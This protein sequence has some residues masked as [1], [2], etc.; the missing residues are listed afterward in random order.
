MGEMDPDLK[1]PLEREN[2][3]WAPFTPENEKVINFRN[4]VE[5]EQCPKTLLKHFERY[6]SN[7]WTMTWYCSVISGSS[8][9]VVA[10]IFW[11]YAEF[12]AWYS[13]HE[14]FIFRQVSLAFHFITWEAVNLNSELCKPSSGRLLAG[15]RTTPSASWMQTAVITFQANV[16]G[17]TGC[18][19]Q[20]K[21]KHGANCGGANKFWEEC[22]AFFFA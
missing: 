1:S 3:H 8:F 9:R 20:E 16:S 11:L 17:P 6:W 5:D 2:H 22:A 10:V 21:K 13:R 7:C 4:V 18:L 14:H 12:T 19:W 15:S